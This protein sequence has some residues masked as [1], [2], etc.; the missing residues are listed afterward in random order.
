MEKI[1]KIQ[2][3][4][5]L[6]YPR[7]CHLCNQ[8]EDGYL[9]VTCCEH[10][11][12]IEEPHCQKCGEPFDGNISSEFKCPNCQ[13]LKLTFDFAIANMKNHPKSRQLV[14]DFKYGKQHH[15]ATPLA[16]RCWDTIQTDPRLH[17]CMEEPH[18]WL[19]CPVPLHW[20]RKLKRTFNQSEL[21]AKELSKLSGIP[22]QNLLKRSKSTGTQ[23]RLN[24]H[25]RLK[26]IQSAISLK[27]SVKPPS[28]ISIILIDDVF[29]TGSTAEACSKV[30]KK[31]GIAQNLIV[32]TAL[33]G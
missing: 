8:P 28:G 19:L 7:S 6:I 20:K 30:L 29:T 12:R 25:E 13:N 5:D 32:L 21:I 15:L 2:W 26:N 4:L 1:Q 17:H 24:R 23:T 33:R 14:Q 10:L 3:L 16:E 18:S 31:H 22:W 9:C 11:P 27:S